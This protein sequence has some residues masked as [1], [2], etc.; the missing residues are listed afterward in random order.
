MP[1]QKLNKNL[2]N[3]IMLESSLRN[4]I[5]FAC[6]LKT[7]IT[8]TTATVEIYDLEKSNVHYV[9]LTTASM[10]NLKRSI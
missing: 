10:I 3:L 2:L 4:S 9:N 7:Q 5:M 1:T 8:G 6:F